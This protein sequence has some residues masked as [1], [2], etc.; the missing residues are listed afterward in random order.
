MSWTVIAIPRENIVVSTGCLHGLVMQRC[1]FHARKRYS[2]TSVS[3]AMGGRRSHH[4]LVVWPLT[5]RLL[6]LRCKHHNTAHIMS[7]HT[8][9]IFA[10][11][12]IAMQK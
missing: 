3:R 1:A 11:V 10:I 4:R 6:H 5:S 12:A 8:I 2:R 7:P 9:F